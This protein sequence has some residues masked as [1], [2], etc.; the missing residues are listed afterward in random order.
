MIYEC[1]LLYFSDSLDFTQDIFG[2]RLYGYAA[3]GRLGNKIAGVDLVEGCKISHI[4][5]EAGGFD[6]PVETAACGLQDGTHIFAALLSLGGNPLGILPVGRVYGNLPGGIDQS[7]GCEC[8]GVRSDCARGLICLNQFHS[9][10]SLSECIFERWR[11][12]HGSTIPARI[13]STT[14]LQLLSMIA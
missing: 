5:Q 4:C 14:R 3:A 1:R 13:K 8:L 2:E 10:R 12:F 7:V 9:D 6:H 11:L